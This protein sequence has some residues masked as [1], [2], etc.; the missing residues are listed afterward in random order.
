MA[1]PTIIYFISLTY[2]IVQRK[3]RGQRVTHWHAFHTRLPPSN[4]N[5]TAN[6]LKNHTCSNKEKHPKQMVCW[7]IFLYLYVFKFIKN[8]D[9]WP[10]PNPIFWPELTWANSRP[11]PFFAGQTDLIHGLLVF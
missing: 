6:V 3:S 4:L 11:A 2:F 9:Y 5:L 8:K 10:C 1:F 7:F